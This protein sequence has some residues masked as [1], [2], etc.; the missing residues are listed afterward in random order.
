[1]ENI[2]KSFNNQNNAILLKYFSKFRIKDFNHQEEIF[3]KFINKVEEFEKG[4]KTDKI[5]EK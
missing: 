1:M 3:V 4:I 5:N 2:I